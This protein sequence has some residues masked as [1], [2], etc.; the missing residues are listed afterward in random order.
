MKLDCRVAAL[1][2]MTIQFHVII[3]WSLR[4]VDPITLCSGLVPEHSED[5]ANTVM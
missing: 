3:L 1:L 5:L 2:A 4:I